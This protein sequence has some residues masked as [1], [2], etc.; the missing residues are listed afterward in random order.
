MPT[1][2]FLTIFVLIYLIP[3]RLYNISIQLPSNKIN[4]NNVAIN[5]RILSYFSTGQVD[6]KKNTIQSILGNTITLDNNQDIEADIIVLCTGYRQETLFFDDVDLNR[7]Y[8]RIVPLNYRNC[9]FIGFAPSF[10]WVQTSDL[11]SRW[12]LNWIKNTLFMGM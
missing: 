6:Y 3:C 1:S 8:K 9:G 4:R 10:N 2:L 11:Q 7:L 12:F 5:D